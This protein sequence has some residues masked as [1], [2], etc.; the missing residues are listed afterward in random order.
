MELRPSVVADVAVASPG[1]DD[2]GSPLLESEE[3]VASP[4]SAVAA[5]AAAEAVQGKMEALEA[6]VA[7]LQQQLEGQA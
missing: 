1:N 3:D 5:I 4:D 2:K 7:L 6:Q